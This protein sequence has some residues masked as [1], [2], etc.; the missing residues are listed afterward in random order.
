MVSF[1][2]DKSVTALKLT[3]EV[4]GDT[5]FLWGKFSRSG[6]GAG[7]RCILGHGRTDL[8]VALLS[9]L[10][11]QRLSPGCSTLL[12]KDTVNAVLLPL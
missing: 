7:G 11:Q 12:L 6:A 8:R 2:G 4:C 1:R 5:L 10:R 9:C 3:H